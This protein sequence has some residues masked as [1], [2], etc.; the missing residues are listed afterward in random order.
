MAGTI[1]WNFIKIKSVVSE[2]MF[3]MKGNARMNRQ[4]DAWQ[5]RGR[6]ISPPV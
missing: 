6:D 4:M 5:T 3:E 1:L 2:K